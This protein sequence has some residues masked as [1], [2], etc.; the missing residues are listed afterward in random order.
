MKR[1]PLPRAICEYIADNALSECRAY[2]FQRGWKSANKLYPYWDK[3]EAG[4]KT[5]EHYLIFQEKGIRPF[6]M[7]SLEGKVVPIKDN[8]GQV[9][10]TPVS[11]VGEPGYVTIPGDPDKPKSPLFE[12]RAARPGILYRE[13]R[14][15][16]PGIEGTHF[17]R[18]AV[19]NAVADSK[20]VTKKF[21]VRLLKGALG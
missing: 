21:L 3:G 8:T 16:H 13:Q 19:E 11:R 10:Y 5:S 2:A 1:V 6:L 17:M 7:S 15:K 20:P 18:R 14:W 4:V 12:S 9:H